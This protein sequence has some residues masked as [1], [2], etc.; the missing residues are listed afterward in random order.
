MDC[1]MGFAIECSMNMAAGSSLRSCSASHA[2]LDPLLTCAG[3]LAKH[4]LRLP[5]RAGSTGG[6]AAA[7]RTVSAMHA[8]SRSLCCTFQSGGAATASSR[9]GAAS[10]AVAN[11]D[12]SAAG[13]VEREDLQRGQNRP[14]CSQCSM[15]AWPQSAGG[16]QETQNSIHGWSG[17]RAAWCQHRKHRVGRKWRHT[18]KRVHAR[19]RRHLLPCLPCT[20]NRHF[21][22]NTVLAKVVQGPARS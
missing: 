19:H 1:S 4:E 12:G 22:A 17:E 9:G 14:C 13:L 6:A 7:V 2:E 20:T 21:N 15:H 11:L 18:L 8:C 5:L 16:T 10:A 3:F